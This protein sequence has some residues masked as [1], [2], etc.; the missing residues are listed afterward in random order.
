M[1]FGRP[2]LGVENMKRPKRGC[3]GDHPWELKT[4]N[5]Q[6]N[7]ITNAMKR[8]IFKESATGPRRVVFFPR[9]SYFE[10]AAFHCVCDCVGFGLIS[11]L[12]SPSRS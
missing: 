7:T 10:N 3:L 9:A 1:L 4:G 6:I 11:L 5:V 2:P 8:R 12:G